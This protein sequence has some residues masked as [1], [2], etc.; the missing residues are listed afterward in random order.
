MN[1]PDIMYIFRMYFIMIFI[2][3]MSLEGQGKK[4]NKY[5]QAITENLA[6]SKG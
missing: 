5:T 3:A 6:I 2:W 4:I 1:I